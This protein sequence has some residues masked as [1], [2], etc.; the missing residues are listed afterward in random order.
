MK[1]KWGLWVQAC[2]KPWDQYSRV[3]NEREK[4]TTDVVKLN[5]AWTGLGKGEDPSWR[6]TQRSEDEHGLGTDRRGDKSAGTCR[7]PQKPFH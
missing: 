3:E 6:Q 2:I 1:K 5:D 7:E 4:S